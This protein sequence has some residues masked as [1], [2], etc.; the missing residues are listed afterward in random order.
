[1]F[2]SEQT[3]TGSKPENLMGVPVLRLNGKAA[4]MIEKVVGLLTGVQEI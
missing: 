2:T 1:V 4:T 3:Q